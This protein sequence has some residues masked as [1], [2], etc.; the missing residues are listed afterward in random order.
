MT[1]LTT[2]PHHAAALQDN[3]I[4][5]YSWLILIKA[6]VPHSKNFLGNVPDF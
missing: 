1:R 2:A 5:Y 4:I 6:P 3:L